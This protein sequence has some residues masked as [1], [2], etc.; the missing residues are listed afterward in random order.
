MR[1]RLQ[2]LSQPAQAVLAAAV[3]VLACTVIQGG[4]ARARQYGDVRLYEHYGHEM[5]SGRIPYR[6]FFMEYPP[7]SIVT[8]ILPALVSTAHYTT[9]FKILMALCGAAT[10]LLV[11]WIAQ[12]T[13]MARPRVAAV[14]TALAVAPVALGPIVVNAFDLWPT[15]VTVAAVLALVSD[16]DRLGAG[17]LGFGAATK[18]FPA[19]I[20]PAALV[21]IYRR[22][23][24]RAARDALLAFIAVAAATYVVFV[25]IAPGGVWFSTHVQLRRGLQKESFGSAILIALD[26]LGLYKARLDESNPHWSEVTGPAADALAVFSSLCQVAVSL[27]VAALVARRRPDHR[28]LLWA[29]AAAVT[30]FVAFGKIFSPQYLIWLVPVVLLAAGLVE[31]ALLGIALVLT[32]LWF[33]QTIHPFD[34]GSQAWIF[35]IR[36][37]LI[38][39]L[40]AALLLRARRLAL[41]APAAAP[42]TGRAGR[43]RARAGPT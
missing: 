1:H 6:D 19:A 32:Q 8:F 36:D 5:M 43:G 41:A 27:G 18:V 33:V 13:G 39:A 12:V 3:F 29:A 17:L 4:L 24:R 30:G 20:L 28:T 40:L 42:R 34:L 22:S 23:G 37:A 21:W 2:N 9:L 15:L 31:V 16:R 35:V 14:L 38:L 10:V 25:V 26:Q 7:G 11:T